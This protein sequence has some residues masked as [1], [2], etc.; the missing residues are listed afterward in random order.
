LADQAC[1]KLERFLRAG[2]AC[3]A[4]DVLANFPELTEHPDLVVDV[5]GLEFMLRQ[6]LG[7]APSVADFCARFP[8]WSEALR[9]RLTPLSGVPNC[10]LADHPTMPHPLLDLRSAGDRT[11]NGLL[12]RLGHYELLERI[13]RGGMGDVYRAR[14]CP[15]LDRVVALKLLRTGEDFEVRTFTRE[16]EVARRLRHP[17]LLPIYDAG[18]LDGE[19]Y[20]TMPLMSGGSLEKRLRRGRVEPRWAAA[21][22][23]KTARA[24]HYA[25]QQR[26]L[27]R[28]LKPANILLDDHDEPLIAD[29]G[30]AKLLDQTLGQTQPGLLLGSVPYMSPEQASGQ[31]HRAT[32]ASDVWSLGVILYEMLAGRRPFWGEDSSEIRRRIAYQEPFSLRQ[33]QT[34]APPELEAICSKCLEKESAWRYASAGE[35]ADDLARWLK[36]ETC[37]PPRRGLADRV[38]YFLYRYPPRKAGPILTATCLIL[39]ALCYL[40]LPVPT[41]SSGSSKPIDLN[42]LLQQEDKSGEGRPLV[43]IAPE[44]EPAGF[45]VELGKNSLIVTSKRGQPLRLEAFSTVLVEFLP[46]NPQRRAG[47]LT[48]EMCQVEGEKISQCGLYI[49]RQKQRFQQGVGHSFAA[50]TY[51]EFV[52]PE[53]RRLLLSTQFLHDTSGHGPVT[54]RRQLTSLSLPAHPPVQNMRPWRTFT[55]TMSAQGVQLSVPGKPAKAASAEELTKAFLHLK[56]AEKKLTNIPLAFSPTGGIGL[57]LHRTIMEIRR[58]EFEPSAELP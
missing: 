10:T 8:L 31:G 19:Y 25:H 47:R 35:L 38:E 40:L 7:Q 1:D 14:Q 49:G 55:L 36:G 27:H 11:R 21:V 26:V 42:A 23:E 28:D 13:G 51:N 41:P 22:V 52:P 33:L 50:A 43:L 18:Y 6:Q 45:R 17:N 54:L 2:E 39:L 15:P 9:L 24:V 32:P 56:D 5:I 58:L 44:E 57:R 12:R 53:S 46:P 34:D 4:E 37:P 16:I 29:F 48:V 20:Y 3:R 30:L